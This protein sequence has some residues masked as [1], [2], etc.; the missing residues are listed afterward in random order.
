MRLQ[1]MIFWKRSGASAEPM[2]PTQ[3]RR[4]PPTSTGTSPEVSRE[5]AR[6]I[7]LPHATRPNESGTPAPSPEA[8][9]LSTPKPGG[10]LCVHEFSEFFSQNYFGFGRY[11]GSRFK[12]E[13]ALTAELASLV[14]R[15][16][17]IAATLIER[18]RVRQDQLRSEGLALGSLSPSMAQRLRLADEQMQ[19]EIDVLLEQIDLA[20]KR[21][22]WV[23]DALNRYR[24]GFDRGLRE[25]LEY[26]L[27]IGHEQ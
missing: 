23:L 25:A 16:Q 2:A 9:Q 26:E 22:G 20:E 14:A 1:R 19:R 6:V 7:P 21:R 3:E 12:S 13:E 17:N 8:P 4:D 15:F 24:L 5:S 10:L 11:S 27:L 18:R